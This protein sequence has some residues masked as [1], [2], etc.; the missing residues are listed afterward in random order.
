[1]ASSIKKLLNE[2]RYQIDSLFFKLFSH[3]IKLEKFK[4]LMKDEPLVI[5]GNGPS[6]NQ[7]PLNDFIGITSI[8]MNKIHLMYEKVSWRPDFLFICNRHVFEQTS[9]Y[10]KS[11][12]GD[13]M[14]AYPSRWWKKNKIE[15]LKYFNLSQKTF[16]GSDF[17]NGI[18][19]GG[20]VTYAAMQFAYY[21]GA[22]PIVLLGIDHNFTYHGKSNELQI[23]KGDDLNH[24]HPNY[25]GEGIK[26]NLPDLALSEYSY[27]LAQAE[28]KKKGVRVYDA[29]VNGKLDIFEKISI[30]SA[31]NILQN[32]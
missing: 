10:L 17:S 28:F 13:V 18:G 31:L 21:L 12:D 27:N 9:N 20:T 25:F 32:R 5:V 24:F 19:A 22:N 15:N 14:V 2:K 3:N 8:G 29:T 7:T 26:W 30:D 1:M 11:F 4:G 6:L 23:A 16:F